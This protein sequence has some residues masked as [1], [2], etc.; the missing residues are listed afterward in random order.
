MTSIRYY[1]IR[2]FCFIVMMGL[3]FSCETSTKKYKV[4]VVLYHTFSWREKLA[5]E[6]KYASLAYE[7]VEFTSVSSY[8]SS[9]RQ[10]HQIDSLMEK[11]IDLLV[12]SPIPTPEVTASINRCY[13]SG[14]PVVLVD[15]K[16]MDCR[17]TA[18]IGADNEEIGRSVG[19]YIG[20]M[21]GEEGGRILEV[22]GKAGDLSTVE[23][24]KGFVDALRK[25]PASEIVASPYGDWLCDSAMA[26]TRKILIRDSNID[27][28]FYHSDGMI[29]YELQG[30]YASHG[31]RLKVIGVDALAKSPSGIEHVKNNN[32]SASFIYPTRGD[33]VVDLVMKILHRRPFA[34]EEIL[35]TGV[36]DDQNI[37]TIMQQQIEIEALDSQI[38]SMRN[39]IDISQTESILRGRI[40]L[41]VTVMFVLLTVYCYTLYRAFTKNRKLHHTIEQQYAEKEKQ[42][43][44]LLES[45]QRL[46][47]L[48]VQIEEEVRTKL[49][50][51][52]NVSHEFRTPLTLIAGP[53]EKL[54]K[55]D[56]LNDVQRRNLL[57]VANKNLT[58]LMN[59]V[60][61]ILDFRKVQDGRMELRNEKFDLLKAM[62]DWIDNFRSYALS[63]N[64]NLVFSHNSL[65]TL[66]VEADRKKLTSIIVNLLGNAFKY[67]PENGTIE[68]KLSEQTDSFT[69]VVSDTGKGIAPDSLPRIFEGFYQAPGT[70]GGTGIG[71]SFVKSLV[72]LHKGTI[73]AESEEGC[74]SVFT[75]VMPKSR[76]L[77]AAPTDDADDEVLT[78]E[79]MLQ[80]DAKVRVLIID[81]NKDMCQYVR[82]LLE[83]QYNCE[84]AYDGL[85]GY[86]KA[87]QWLP[88]I[89]ICDVMMP[90]M[91]G[92]QCCQKLKTTTATSHI[93]VIL[94]TARSLESNYVEGFDNGADAYITKPFSAEV[95]IARIE[96]LLNSRK[97]L[98]NAFSRGTQ[99]YEMVAT[100]RESEFVKRFQSYVNEGI[101][102]PDF[103]IEELS[104]KMN[105]SRAQLYAKIK[106]LTGQAPVEH[107]ITARLSRSY[108]L[109]AT[110]E[111][112]VAEIA[113]NVGF[114]SPAYF[115]KCFKGQYNM[116]PKEFRNSIKQQ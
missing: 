5:N 42:A 99:N 82:M 53:I 4:G 18:F 79:A 34:H 46:Q 31:K 29:W 88:E 96:N 51:F 66:W 49:N 22:Q 38:Q 83:D 98:R 95:L 81:D 94:L 8:N 86:E 20:R 68:V 67:T 106:N 70:Q 80:Q 63:Q 23:R 75:I 45:N 111:M 17:R 50:F 41:L 112:S 103:G 54:L 97:L 91:D 107:L 61:D 12:I 13:D 40:T 16:S 73:T 21:F 37:A 57:N 10:V 44:Q 3:L 56:N 76:N 77:H 78:E 69:I 114:S 100:P 1:I 43:R 14:I 48:N 24:H 108:E 89:I 28:V 116:T 58:M 55:N 30:I 90:V 115:S 102:N 59:L 71:L 35:H 65:R 47:Q 25:Y 113:Y 101:A 26:V 84:E 93:P 11:G 36:V 104:E 72:E 74:G 7:D 6:I 62:K 2:V 105:L 15:N 9:Q 33:K 60:S 19:E 32:I 109:L 92:I 27:A 39:Q 87:Q 64:V 110:T 85:Q 52:T